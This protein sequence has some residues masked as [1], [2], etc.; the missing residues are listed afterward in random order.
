MPN[1]R[2][3]MIGI[4]AAGPIN[5]LSNKIVD[6][7]SGAVFVD[8]ASANLN[9]LGHC[10]CSQSSLTGLEVSDKDQMHTMVVKRQQ[11]AGGPVSLEHPDG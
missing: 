8:L 11:D 7:A 10:Y 9:V 2:D 5:Q 1:S 4:L 6:L 3:K